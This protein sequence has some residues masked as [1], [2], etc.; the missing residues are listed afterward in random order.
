MDEAVQHLSRLLDQVTLVGIVLQLLIC[1]HIGSR[2][3]KWGRIGEREYSAC[4]ITLRRLL[5]Q[6][7]YCHFK[8]ASHLLD[9]MKG[10]MAPMRLISEV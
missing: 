5:L 7:G 6:S 3:R 8:S 10:K 4:T 2:Y 1:R 9:D